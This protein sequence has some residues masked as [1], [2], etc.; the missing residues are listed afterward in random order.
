MGYD[1]IILAGESVK[2]SA[3]YKAISVTVPA[4][5]EKA[6][7]DVCRKE[8]RKK[9]EVVTEALRLY[10]GARH[11]K[12]QS[13]TLVMPA[14]EEEGARIDYGAFADEWGSEHD[15]VYDQLGK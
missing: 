7:A 13:W 5:M 10:F 15:A 14:G 3:R 4:D 2:T 8:I 9:S 12:R 11:G 1:W 6:L